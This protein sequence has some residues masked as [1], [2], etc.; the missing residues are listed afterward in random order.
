[1][2]F[3]IEIYDGL[4]L[5]DWLMDEAIPL[6]QQW[7]YEFTHDITCI[8]YEFNGLEFSLDLEWNPDSKFFITSIVEGPI[9]QGGRFYEKTSNTIDQLK[10]DFSE[11]VNLIQS[12]KNMEM[13]EILE[14]KIK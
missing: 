13:S 1:M 6:K 4:P 2:F 7:F 3:G 14:K 5:K 9:S 8:N 12:F 11:A 10:L